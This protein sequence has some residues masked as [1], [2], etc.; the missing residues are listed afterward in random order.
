MEFTLKEGV[1]L[2][3]S[4]PLTRYQDCL[5]KDHEHMKHSL[6]NGGKKYGQSCVKTI[7]FIHGRKQLLKIAKVQ[8]TYICVLY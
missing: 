6:K 5:I 8:C 4:L 3:L 2:R 1:V 7:V